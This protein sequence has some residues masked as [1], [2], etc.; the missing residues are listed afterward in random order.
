MSQASEKGWGAAAQIVKAI[1]EQRGWQ[2]HGH[3]RL[4]AVVD[5]LRNETGDEEICR[6]FDVASALHVNFYE[7]WRS[8]ENV[9]GGL[10]DVARL[11]D[12]LEPMAEP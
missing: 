11:V 3:G 1:A 10:D 12:K 9:G 7:D 4:F 8:A 5:R 2:H 6:L